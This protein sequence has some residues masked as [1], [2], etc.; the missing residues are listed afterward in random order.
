VGNLAAASA[1]LLPPLSPLPLPCL[2]TLLLL[3]QSPL[4]P[5]PEA[6]SSLL[7]LLLLLPAVSAARLADAAAF[8]TDWCCS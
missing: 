6:R 4:L 5:R 1:P 3:C 2:S 8:L 7:L